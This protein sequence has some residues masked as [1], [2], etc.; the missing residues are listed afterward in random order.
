MQIIYLLNNVQIRIIGDTIITVVVD[1]DN[2]VMA[3]QMGR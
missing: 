3:Y 2:N 1:A